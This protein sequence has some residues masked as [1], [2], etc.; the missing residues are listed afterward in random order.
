MDMRLGMAGLL[1]GDWEL[2]SI[3][4]SWLTYNK[5]PL[6]IPLPLPQALL[7]PLSSWACGEISSVFCRCARARP[8]IGVNHRSAINLG[9]WSWLDP[10]SLS[11]R[12][13]GKDYRIGVE[14][15]MTE[16]DP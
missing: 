1:L 7:H 13:A 9:E 2:P 8:G 4:R 12:A 6:P 16:V 3:R 15:E 14:H 11:S 5:W 10:L